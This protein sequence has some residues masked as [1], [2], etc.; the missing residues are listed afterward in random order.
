MPL[1]VS[2]NVQTDRLPPAVESTAYFV[3]CEALA[4]I[5]K[6]ADARRAAITVRQRNGTVHLTVEDDGAGGASTPAGGGLAGLTD[7]V[8]A[9]GGLLRLDSPAGRGTRLTAE[10]PCES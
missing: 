1:P 8:T 9:L 5:V 10:L 6:H 7:R 2:V 3:I 4:N